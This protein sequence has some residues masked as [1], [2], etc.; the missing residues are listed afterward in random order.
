MNKTILFLLF[1]QISLAQILSATSL[2]R[3]NFDLAELTVKFKN[4]VKDNVYYAKSKKVESYLNMGQLGEIKDNSTEKQQNIN[5]VSSLLPTSLLFPDLHVLKLWLRLE[6]D[7]Q[8][9]LIAK[10]EQQKTSIRI[11]AI[12]VILDLNVFTEEE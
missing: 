10:I 7:Q 5:I 8:L 9:K 4:N 1:T 6:D 11:G 2:N 3:R 12:K